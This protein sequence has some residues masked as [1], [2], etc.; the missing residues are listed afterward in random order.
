MSNAPKND[1]ANQR[2]D[3]Q[4]IAESNGSLPIYEPLSRVST[5]PPYTIFTSKEKTLIMALGAI[6]AL[7]SPL[8]T[9]IYYPTLIDLTHNLGVSYTAPSPQEGLQAQVMMNLRAN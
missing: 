7:L 2:P 9:N 1:N 3:S 8:A 5:G 6:G 4:P